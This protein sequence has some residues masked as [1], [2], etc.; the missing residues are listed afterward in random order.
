MPKLKGPSPAMVVA[1]LAL[2]VA[3]SGVGYA[4]VKIPR[5]SVG[6][7]QLKADAVTGPKVKANTLGGADINEASLQG[8]MK[9]GS[10]AGGSLTGTFPNPAIGVEKVGTIE[11]ENG[12]LTSADIDE[13][14]LNVVHGSGE[15]ATNSFFLAA[16]TL[17]FEDVAL[18]PGAGF[19]Q[20]TCNAGATSATLRYR[21]TSGTQT[22]VWANDG[23]GGGTKNLTTSAG[24]TSAT[25][26]DTGAFGL[27]TLYVRP[28]GSILH[29]SVLHLGATNNGTD[30][31]FF[32]NVLRINP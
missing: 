4:A 28:G 2:A 30:C 13:S 15:A 24:G 17:V 1:C 3:L 7:N 31:T 23:S 27:V 18:V 21:D 5:N 11:V 25:T 20:A 6:T 16:N 26:I 8:L 22:L 9:P 32:Y 14:T 10:A 29:R 19:V 12:S